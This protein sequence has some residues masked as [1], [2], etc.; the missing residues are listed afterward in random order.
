MW[1]N[2]MLPAVGEVGEVAE[3][4]ALGLRVVLGDSCGWV[5]QCLSW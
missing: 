3:E 1:A 4:V 5:W 2:L